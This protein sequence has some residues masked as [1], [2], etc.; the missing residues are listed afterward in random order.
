MTSKWPI[1][2]IHQGH[3][4]KNHRDITVHPR[5]C[6]KFKSMITLVVGKD[7]EPKEHAHMHF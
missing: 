3:A 5:Q 2:F 1:D 7:I 6:L 4:N